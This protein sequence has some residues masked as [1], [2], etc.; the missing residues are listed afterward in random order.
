[1]LPKR[2]LNRLSGFDYSSDGFYFVTSCVHEM[3]CCLGS[4]QH[5]EMILNEFGMIAER[6]WVW[7]AERYPYVVV[8]DFV[9][10]PNHVHGILEIDGNYEGN[11][12]DDFGEKVARVGT[13]RELSVHKG[14]P[15]Q[16]IKSVSGLIGAFKTTSSKKI[17]QAGFESFAWQRSFHDHIIRNEAEYERISTYIKANPQKWHEDRFHKK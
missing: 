15:S 12:N 2:K 17:H 14:N 13:A 11:L 4:V 7:L 10:M 1:M 16:K 9:V 8:H 3:Q 5:G 6:Q